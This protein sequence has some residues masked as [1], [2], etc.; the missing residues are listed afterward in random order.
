[1]KDVLQSINCQEKNYLNFK[2]HLTQKVD[3]ENQKILIFS[4]LLEI[5]VIDKAKFVR[6]GILIRIL[7][8]QRNEWIQILTC[9]N[10]ALRSKSYFIFHQ[11]SKVATSVE[12]AT[13]KF[14]SSL[15]SNVKASN[16]KMLLSFAYGVAGDVFM[17]LAE[18][19]DEM[20]VKFHEGFNNQ[21]SEVDK[22]I[23]K[24]VEDI[25]DESMRE[26]TLKVQFIFFRV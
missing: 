10:L 20:W 9:I 26:W 23:A 5:C 2:C 1:M 6:E 13:L 4:H 7:Q 3:H 19:W 16:V 17:V 8:L 25:V 11:W 18:K 24:A 12:N 21:G 15:D 22:E 14:Q